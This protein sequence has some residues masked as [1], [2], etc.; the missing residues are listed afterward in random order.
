MTAELKARDD[1]QTITVRVPI[2]IR[3]RGGRKLVLASDGN[4]AAAPVTRHVDIHGQGDC[5]GVPV[6]R[7]AGKR[8][9]RD[10]RGD[11]C[12]REDQRILRRARAE[13]EADAAGAGHCRGDTRWTAAG[14][15]NAGGANAAVSGALV[16]AEIGISAL[17]AMTS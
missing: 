11:R 3:R 2:A 8:N 6:A 13:A 9:A 7:P 15:D 17:T 14:A 1:G 10:D 16:C 4:V 5:P 12:S